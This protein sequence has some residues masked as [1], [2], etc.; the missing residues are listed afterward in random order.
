MQ[1][2]YSQTAPFSF[3][4]FFFVKKGKIVFFYVCP[5]DTETRADSLERFLFSLRLPVWAF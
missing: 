5:G 3:P 4:H 1:N 2:A